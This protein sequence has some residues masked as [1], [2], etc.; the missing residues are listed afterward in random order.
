MWQ[1]RERVRSICN[2]IAKY[3]LVVL[4]VSY[5]VGGTAFTHTHYFPTYSVTHSHPFL[6]G[7]DGLPHHTHNSAAFNTIEELDDI[8]MEAAALCFTLATAW[9]LLFV[10]IEQHKYITPIRL[11]RN[12]SLRAPPFC[13][14]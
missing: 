11:V 5:Y 14:K 13:I 9:L 2:A 7:A 12:V 6:P 10:F 4:F 3:L 8:L 1:N